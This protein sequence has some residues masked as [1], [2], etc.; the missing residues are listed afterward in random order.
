MGS[1]DSTMKLKLTLDSLTVILYCGDLIPTDIDPLTDDEWAN[2]EAV[3]SKQNK[4]VSA[5]IGMRY[6]AMTQILGIDERI[7]GK[8]IARAQLLPDLFH[9][10]HN[11]ENEHIHV[12]T[13]YEDDYPEQLRRLDS[14]MPLVLYSSGNLSLI[15]DRVISVAGPQNTTRHLNF[16]T[17]NIVTKACDEGRALAASNNKGVEEYAVRMMLR[18]GG[19]VILFV[20]DHMLDN[21][22]K[23]K[24]QIR[25]GQ[26]VLLCAV[27][28]YAYFNVTHTLDRNIYICGLSSMQ[29]VVGSKINSGATWFTA[30]QNLHYHWTRLLVLHRMTPD[31]YYSGNL[32]L[33]ELGAVP[34]TRDNLL[35]LMSFDDIIERNQPVV[36]D[37]VVID[38]MSI[39]EFLPEE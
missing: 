11:M 26:M 27:D 5:L 32:R 28:P 39:F 30:V 34:V 35:S 19:K 9:A 15:D 13:K 8:M 1:E 29:I 23:Y 22:R 3:L 24:K 10:L 38:Q 14:R 37:D 16:A 33:V 25:E 6:E 12:T 21:A 18:C 31:E 2:V 20:S 7:A 36:N 4:D 17:K